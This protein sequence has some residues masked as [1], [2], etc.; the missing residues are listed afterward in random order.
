MSAFDEKHKIL[1]SILYNEVFV[2]CPMDYEEG[3]IHVF[4]SLEGLLQYMKCV[5]VDSSGEIRVLNG[6]LTPASVLPSTAGK[7][8]VYILSFNKDNDMESM[9]LCVEAPVDIEKIVEEVKD[10]VN[11][12]YGVTFEPD[13]ETIFILY[14]YPMS[15]VLAPDDDD[16]D[17]EALEECEKISTEVKEIF[18]RN[19]IHKMED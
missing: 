17:E 2:V 4:E 7:Q 19:V 1:K 13:I 18:V 3:E 16:M 8:N 15:I 5:P 9:S 6:F 10:I 11:D 12:S 14:G